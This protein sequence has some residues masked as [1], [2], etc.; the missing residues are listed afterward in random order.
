M[1]KINTPTSDFRQVLRTTS[2]VAKLA[3]FVALDSS[4][5]LNKFTNFVTSG[6]VNRDTLAK[7]VLQY[8]VQ[9]GVQFAVKNKLL[10]ERSAELVPQIKKM[11]VDNNLAEMKVA[12]AALARTGLS[13]AMDSNGGIATIRSGKA[14]VTELTSQAVSENATYILGTNATEKLLHTLVKA[15]GWQ[16]LDS[17]LQKSFSSI[18]AGNFIAKKNTCANRKI[19]YSKFDF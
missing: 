4:E 19:Y 3:A 14:V 11:L 15:H 2:E 9:A 7:G 12:V 10:G 18:P 17:Y 16:P 1:D 8:A 5:K 13:G 6:A